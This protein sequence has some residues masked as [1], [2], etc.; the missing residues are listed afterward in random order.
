MLALL[1]NKISGL[2]GILALF[3]GYELSP[4]QLS[5]YIY[6]L[7]VLG[8]ALWLAPAIRTCNALKVLA[9]AWIY[10]LDTVV[11]SVYTAL[12]GMG[13]FIL[14]AQHLNDDTTGAD[15]PGGKMM[16][17]TSGFTDPEHNV[18][19][20]EVVATPAPGLMP[21]QEAVAY[22][23]TGGSLGGTVFQ[24]GSMASLTVLCVLW[25]IR[26][27]FCIIVF[28]Y[29]RSV[30]RQYIVQT[31]SSSYSQSDDPHMADNPFRA[32]REEGQ[33]WKGAL[34]RAMLKFPKRYWLGKAD[35]D[36]AWVRGVNDK[37]AGNKL[38]IHVP[39]PGVGERERRARSGTGPPKPLLLKEQLA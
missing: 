19:N 9:L 30:L 24:S 34:G 33:G 14:L 10:I 32:G 4:V 23:T 39:Q 17:D 38:R 37:L 5:H 22:G 27:Y 11:N 3:T 20:V 18:S 13:W 29:A 15:G 8:L 16:N 2:Y 28:S 1:L 7:F 26:I 6:S 21:G 25:I 12:F 31:S 35:D 36:E